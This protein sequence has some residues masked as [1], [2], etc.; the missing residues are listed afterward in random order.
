MCVGILLQSSKMSSARLSS[1]TILTICLTELGVID[2]F[3]LCVC[4]HFQ[5]ERWIINVAFSFGFDLCGDRNEY[6]SSAPCVSNAD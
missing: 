6:W 5:G 2:E 3:P 4:V 1:V